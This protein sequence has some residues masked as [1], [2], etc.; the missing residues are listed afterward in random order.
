MNDLQYFFIVVYSFI[1][2]SK[3]IQVSNLQQKKHIFPLL[4]EVDL[5]LLRPSLTLHKEEQTQTDVSTPVPGERGEKKKT[6][7][8]LTQYSGE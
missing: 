6:H 8:A 2:S 4:P 1:H 7:A 3:F 5:A